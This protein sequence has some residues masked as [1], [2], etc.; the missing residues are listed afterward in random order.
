MAYGINQ[1]GGF[2]EFVAVNRRNVYQINGLSYLEGAMVEPLG[3]VIHGLKQIDLKLGAHVLIFGCGPI[4]LL[5][6]QACN[7]YGAASTTVADVVRDKLNI[8]EQLGA[9]NTVYADDELA[10]KLCEIR[11]DGF[12]IVIDATGN[13]KVVENC[14]DYVRNKGQ[15]LFF[16]VCPQKAKIEVSP[17]EVYKRELKISGTFAI[18]HTA[19]PAIEL[20]QE[21]K[22]Q[23]EPLI[24][25]QFSLEEFESAFELKQDGEA[26]KIMI[27]N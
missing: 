14:F 13:P 24:S 21:K 2:E 15:I 23:V 19:I 9:T 26:M 17:Y 5:L 25:H 11:S 10:E 18:L 12:H 7:I 1:N 16:G 20:L 27:T 4:G 22:I 6:M 8:A 3:C